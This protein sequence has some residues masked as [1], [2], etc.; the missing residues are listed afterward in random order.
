MKPGAEAL[1]VTLNMV[2]NQV[3]QAYYGEE[4]QRLPRDGEDVRVMVRYPFE[5]RNS[6]DSLDDFRIRTSDGREIALSQ[7]AETDFA[8][9]INRIYRRDRVRSAAVFAELSG[10]VRGQIMDDMNENFW[11]EFGDRFPSVEHGSLGDAES[12]GE[13]LTSLFTLNLGAIMLMY[14]LLSIAFKSYFQPILLMMAI[15]FSFAGA[16]FGHL[17]FGVPLAMFSMFGIAAA[18]GV[19]I[20]DNLVLIDS[21]NRRRN[22][23]GQGAIQALVE[24]AVS[25]FRPILLT[26]VT[27]FVGVLPMIANKSVQAQLLKP[28]VISM[29]AAVAFA[30]FVSLFFV[31][32]LYAVGAEIARIFRWLWSG[33]PYQPIGATYNSDDVAGVIDIDDH[34]HQQPAE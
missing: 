19:V 10:D 28:M 32:A 34:M 3:R 13:M 24:S 8:P 18:A 27:T 26:S 4:V 21:V 5:A 25:R 11:P 33:R 30:L 7:V 1:G 9:G 16:V 6:L 2:S 14:V 29:G 22:E 12:E 23:L 15:P 20:N 31:P 17:L